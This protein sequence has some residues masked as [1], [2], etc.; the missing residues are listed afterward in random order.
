MRGLVRVEVSDRPGNVVAN[1]RVQIREVDTTDPVADLYADKV[2]GS[3]LPAAEVITDERGIATAWIEDPRYVDAWVTDNGAQAYY[4]GNPAMKLTFA[5]FTVSDVAPE[6]PDE[7]RP[8]IPHGDTHGDGGGDPIPGLATGGALAAE[9]AARI[10]ADDAEAAER[11]D[12]DASILAAL[13]VEEAAR[14][15]ADATKATTSDLN[16]ET[17]ARVAADATKAPKGIEVDPVLA[18]AIEAAMRPGSHQFV[19]APA[20]NIHGFVRVSDYLF[21]GHQTSPGRITRF[22]VDDLNDQTTYVFPND[23]VHTGGEAIVYDEG[24]GRLYLLHPNSTQVTISEIDPE[25]LAATDKVAEN[26]VGGSTNGAAAGPSL[27]SDGTYLYVLTQTRPA[28]VLKYALADGALIDSATLTNSNGHALTH[29][30]EYLYATGNI[31]GTAVAATPYWVAKLDLATLTAVSEV[32]AEASYRI[33]TDDICVVGDY[34]YIGLEDPPGL[35]DGVIQRRRVSDLGLDTNI[36]VAGV[37][38]AACYGTHWDGKF[39]WSLWSTTPGLA[40]LIDPQTLEQRRFTFRTG[41]NQP[42]E[43]ATDGRRV[44]FTHWGNPAKVSRYTLPTL[45]G[46]DLATQAELDAHAADTTAVHG[47]AD[48]TALVVTTDPRLSDART[49]TPHGHPFT[50]IT[51]TATDAQIPGTIARD[52]EVTSAIAAHEADTTAVHGVADTTQLVLTTDSRLGDIDPRRASTTLAETA[53]RWLPM[54][55]GLSVLVSGRLSL[56][57]IWLPAGLTVTAITF[58]SGSTSAGTPTGYRFGLYDSNRNLLRQTVDGGTAA[59]NSF[60]S[61]KTLALTSTFTTT[62]AGIYYLGIYVVAATVPNLSGIA[63]NNRMISAAPAIFG[64]STT[65]LA[66]GADMPNPA[67]AITSVSALPYAQVR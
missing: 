39:V 14:I 44:F 31:V 38:T 21:G 5:G 58:F 6:E 25:T 54:N 60:D 9:T 46:T 12:A 57:A 2:G 34:L 10:E 8:P 27:T 19:S 3:P 23:G 15:S 30:G 65:G 17:A 20:A 18:S 59:W 1:A 49:P 36:V 7:P 32:S 28:L 56:A 37:G 52:A 29:D 53:P 33:A 13:G 16:S 66:A 64:S 22:H 45:T 61:G 43:F 51:G 55:E 67:A 40:V 26:R 42:N 4:P 63:S 47:I 62:Y 35:T 48:T 11:S 24:R 50:D 41:Q